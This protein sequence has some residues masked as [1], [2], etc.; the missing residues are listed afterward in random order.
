L[1]TVKFIF[2]RLGLHWWLNRFNW[3]IGLLLGGVFRILLT[4]KFIFGRLGLHWWLNRFNWLI[5]LRR[6]IHSF[7]RC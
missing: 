3:L 1:L 7:S 4:V 6:R 2:G 5:G